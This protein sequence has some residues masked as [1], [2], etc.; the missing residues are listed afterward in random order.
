MKIQRRIKA[1][2]YIRGAEEPFEDI[3]FD[4]E[5]GTDFKDVQVSDDSDSL[6]DNIEDMA[7]TLADI[8]DNVEQITQEDPNIDI[9]NNI[10]NH[11]I[12]ECDRCHGIFISAMVQSEQNVDKISGICP[13][14]DK[15]TDQYLKWVINSVNND[16]A[17]IYDR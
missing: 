12:A 3:E 11:Y 10:T 1:S 7:D 15:H 5:D 13:L 2:S 8:Q 16:D 14:C 17:L 6:Y 9:D 4:D